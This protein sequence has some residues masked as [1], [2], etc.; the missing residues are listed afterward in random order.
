MRS[1]IEQHL[2]EAQAIANRAERENRSLTKNERE[3]AE[4][5]LSR[6]R[7]LKASQAWAEGRVSDLSKD[8]WERRRNQEDQAE[9]KAQIEAMNG[10]LNGGTGS[11]GD[12]VFKAGFSL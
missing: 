8:D 1:E 3:R 2:A 11:F 12:A 5:A 9:L 4:E 7:D 10:S 6:V